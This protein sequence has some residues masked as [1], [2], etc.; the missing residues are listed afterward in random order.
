MSKNLEFEY[1]AE[2]LENGNYRC[3]GRRFDKPKVNNA[4]HVSEEERGYPTLMEKVVHF[5]YLGEVSH[6]QAD[7]QGSNSSPWKFYEY[8]DSEPYLNMDDMYGVEFDLYQVEYE[9]L[10]IMDEDAQGNIKTNTTYVYE[11]VEKCYNLNAYEVE[12]MIDG[13]ASLVQEQFGID[14]PYYYGD[15][16]NDE[17][18][19]IEIKL[20]AKN[21]MSRKVK[22]LLEDAWQIFNNYAESYKERE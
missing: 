18:H 16:Y 13:V 21:L 6:L 7:S 15:C 11:F 1:I 2:R 22:D 12:Q 19:T 20:Q 4:W 9:T 8:G 17:I 3:Y 5:D 10:D 14:N